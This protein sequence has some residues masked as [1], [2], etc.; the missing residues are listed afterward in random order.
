MCFSAE[1]DFVGAAVAGAIGVATLREPHEA[2]ELPLALLPLG[3]ALHQVAEGVVWLD[4]EGTAPKSV[5]NV[6][7]YA[8][9]VYAWALLPL[10]VPLSVMLAEPLRARRRWIGWLLALGT[11]A[12]TYLMWSMTQGNV[13]A[14][15]VDHAIEYG[16]AGS[17]ADVVTVLYV[18]ATCGAFLLSSQRRI[19]IFG[20]FNLFAVLVLVWVRAEALTSLWCAWAAIVSLFIYL[21]FADRRRAAEA[22]GRVDEVTGPRAG[23]LP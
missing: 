16:G 8:Y 11:I 12:G 13:T 5:G 6:A 3:F 14:R 22:L 21:H 4:L 23:L 7:L 9:L 2:R 19:V 15:I 20:I 17:D 1:A 18:V 10:L